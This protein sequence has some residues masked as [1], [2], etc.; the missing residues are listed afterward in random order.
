MKQQV[1]KINLWLEN[2]QCLMAENICKTKYEIS[3]LGVLMELNAFVR[4]M[5]DKLGTCSIIFTWH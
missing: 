5:N 3:C 2:A 1:P 4:L